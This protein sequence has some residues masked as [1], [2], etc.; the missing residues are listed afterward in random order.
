MAEIDATGEKNQGKFRIP[1][2]M[3]IT[4]SETKAGQFAG[5]NCP[6][7]EFIVKKGCLNATP[8]MHHSKYVTEEEWLLPPYTPIEW[9]KQEHRNFAGQNRLVVTFRVLDGMRESLELPSCMIMVRKDPS[10][11]SS[12]VVPQNFRYAAKA[13]AE[14]AKIAS[15]Q[16][17]AEAECA[18]IASLQDGL[19]T[20]LQVIVEDQPSARRAELEV[21]IRVFQEVFSHRPTEDTKDLLCSLLE[22]FYYDLKSKGWTHAEAQV[23][24]D[25]IRRAYESQ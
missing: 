24:Q 22:D 5:A 11:A 18:K 9:V 7:L 1:K 14:C 12:G 13:E 23:I 16:P 8:I 17:K 2:Y 10:V 19:P 20:P 21:L 3:S 4:E 25:K 15:L 6:I